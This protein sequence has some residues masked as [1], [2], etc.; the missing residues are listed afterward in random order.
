MRN[1]VYMVTVLVAA[2]SL[3]GPSAAGSLPAPYTPHRFIAGA[4]DDA[5][6]R[7]QERLAQTFP[8][9]PTD[10]S[11]LEK[12]EFRA[13]IDGAVD[14][15][16]LE[17][18]TCR[19][20]FYP[21]AA[22]EA[23]YSSRL[24][25]LVWESGG[26]DMD[27]AIRI[28]FRKRYQLVLDYCRTASLLN[29][30]R[31]LAMVLQDRETVLRRKVTTDMSHDVGAFLSARDRLAD[32]RLTIAALKSRME[33]L[34]REIHQAAGFAAEIAFDEGGLIMVDR[35]DAILSNLNPALDENMDLLRLRQKA[36]AT[37]AE[38]RLE[39]AKKNK[40]IEFIEISHAIQDDEKGET[41]LELGIRLPFIGSGREALW[42]CQMSALR[43]QGR[44]EE[45]KT[46]LLEKTEAMV[47]GITELIRQYQCREQLFD[48]CREDSGGMVSLEKQLSAAGSDPL[49]LLKLKET[50]TLSDIKR[51]ELAFEIRSRFIELLDITGRLT[52]K[53]L[54]DYLA[55]VPEPF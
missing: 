16:D 52:Q 37:D 27:A 19:L 55:V 5:L 43:D 11:Y 12:I 31:S 4:Q 48:R 32:A 6:V 26:M 15:P 53:P 14:E 8:P 36:N 54:T 10:N 25:R 38:Y 40:L 28:A 23:A 1:A 51:C 30:H 17:K 9:M 47:Q 41:S 35:I 49:N 24:T 18:Q 22:G 3:Y 45:E 13:G 21:R 33:G 20:R 46:A 44:Y 39:I 34:C 29:Y 42:R 50:G 7:R 2:L